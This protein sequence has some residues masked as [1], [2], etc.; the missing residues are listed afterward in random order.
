V[1]H[2]QAAGFLF[3]LLALLATVGVALLLYEA[4]TLLT[5]RA[6]ITWFVKLGIADHPRFSF[7]IAM[8]IGVLLGHFFWT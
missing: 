7:V 6:P 3:L 4:W 8:L 5:Q 1:S 2:Y